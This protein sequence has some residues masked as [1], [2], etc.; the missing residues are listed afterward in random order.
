MKTLRL[1][2]MALFAILMCVNFA[3][4]SNKENEIIQDGEKV[5][6]SLGFGGDYKISSFPL[7][8]NAGNNDLYYI[9]IKDKNSYVYACGLFDNLNNISIELT[10]G[11][12]YSFSAVIVK[13]GKNKLYNNNNLYSTALFQHELTNSFSKAKITPDTDAFILA[14]EKEYYIANVETYMSQ[15]GFTY[16]PQNDDAIEIPMSRFEAFGADFIA[17][18][19]DE[20]TLKITLEKEIDN[21]II[22]KSPILN[23]Q[24]PTKSVSEIFTVLPYDKTTTDLW[25]SVEG[26][27][28][29]NAIVNITWV[30]GDNSEV[31]L[32]SPIIPFKCGYKTTVEI[33]VDNST[34]NSISFNIDETELG[35]GETYQVEN[36]NA[37][38]QE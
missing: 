36:G 35:N 4:C 7:S 8:R 31:S 38:K 14:D 27:R 21:S 23:I 15:A 5:L 30:K 17:E 6:V 24:H 32:G 10:K 2:G 20:G 34:N 16:S 29:L 19:F 9:N 12:T 37:T 28:V 22:T 33:I 18:Y 11:E 1:I 25:T 3:S 13:D 26:N